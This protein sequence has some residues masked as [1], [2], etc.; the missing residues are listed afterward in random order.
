MRL[1]F[2]LL[3]LCSGSLS[4][5]QALV[6]AQDTAPL[7]VH[8]FEINSYWLEQ[9]SPV[10]L[11]E[12]VQ[13]SDEEARIQRHLQLVEQDL[14]QRTTAHLSAAQRAKRGLALDALH[15]YWRQKA[16]PVNRVQPY[17]LPIF[18]D[19]TGNACAVGAL[20]LAT[21]QA[22]L[23]RQIIQENNYAT[24][25]ELLAY[26]AITHWADEY[27]F[28][29]D[30]LAWI[31][32]Y[33]GVTGYFYPRALGNNQGVAGGEVRALLEANDELYFA[34]SF[35]HIDGVPAQFLAAW[36]GS[37]FRSFSP[38]LRGSGIDKIAV[39]ETT[40]DIYAIG[41][42]VS[43]LNEPG[44]VVLAR[45]RNGIW[46]P[47][48]NNQQVDGAAIVWEEVKLTDI[49]CKDGYCYL[50]GNFTWLN[51]QFIASLA[52]YE[53]A[54][55]TWQSYSPHWYPAGTINDLAI[56]GDTLA[57]GG[58]FVLRSAAGD[59]LGAYMAISTIDD[60]QLQGATPAE[61]ID[62]SRKTVTHLD[63]GS[64]AGF[65]PLAVGLG[66]VDDRRVYVSLLSFNMNQ[67]W[68]TL[69]SQIGG[70]SVPYSAFFGQLDIYGSF[71]SNVESYGMAPISQG[72]NF[73]TTF[74]YVI[75]NGYVTAFCPFRDEIIIAGNFTSLHGI[76]NLRHL[77]VS[78]F[79]RTP[80]S[81]TQATPTPIQIR[82]DGHTIFIEELPQQG[83]LAQFALFDMQGRLV[84]SGP[85]A[86]SLQ[87]MDLPAAAYVY[88]L[89][90]GDAISVGQLV[91]W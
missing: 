19:E 25:E 56:Q 70:V 75:T 4:A 40:G 85:A 67:G 28:T 82:T 16:F 5:Q 51:G 17:R 9:A 8:M 1:S 73:S 38:N 90:V 58:S 50:S 91:L 64:Y 48:F 23:V 69:N 76:D 66:K 36:D 34:G 22:A 11:L 30:E 21:N 3:L 33:Y 62:N 26:P 41:R 24:V 20:L 15:A 71:E 49:I 81:T 83:D 47:I 74:P 12:A 42:F 68:F 55:D 32:P 79:S 59:T 44:T 2:F 77:V 7:Y 14:R 84:W 72:V 65:G 54:S 88:R 53:V 13:F 35:T 39:D 89:K 45:L 63:I 86:P 60:R 78:N 57:F 43:F 37:H 10:G 31:Q 52:V 80:T 29:V 18:V 87:P 6:H 61:Y 27:G 46:E